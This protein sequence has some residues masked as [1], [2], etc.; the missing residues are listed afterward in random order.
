[1]TS[2]HLLEK[3]MLRFG[4]T[5]TSFN[6]RQHHSELQSQTNTP[7]QVLLSPSL[8]LPPAPLL[9]LRKTLPLSLMSHL[10]LPPRCRAP[11]AVLVA[12]SAPLLL[13]PSSTGRMLYQ[14]HLCPFPTLLRENKETGIKYFARDLQRT[15]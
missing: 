15:S 12:A 10:P 3:I 5:R 2:T 6:D 14:K 7:C 11:V 9:S 8:L 1:M 4:I 13:H